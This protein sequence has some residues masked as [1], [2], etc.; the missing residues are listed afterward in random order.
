VFT[1]RRRIVAL[2][3]AFGLVLSMGL[4]ATPVAAGPPTEIGVWPAWDDLDDCYGF[5][6]DETDRAYWT[7][8]VWGGVSGSFHVTASWGDGTPYG[9][10]YVDGTDTYDRHHDFA[11]GHGDRYQTWSASRSG[12][13][14]GHAYTQVMTY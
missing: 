1:V 3:T 7:F 9:N 13:G 11:C 4:A 2:A 12:G 10:W 6:P 5:F 8:S 14:T